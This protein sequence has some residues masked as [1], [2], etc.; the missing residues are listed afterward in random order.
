[1]KD[2][3]THEMDLMVWDENRTGGHTDLSIIWNGD[4]TAQTYADLILV[5]NAADVGNSFLLI[6]DKT[7]SHSARLLENI[8]ETKTV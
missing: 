3:S 2:N 4:L 6:S 5:L 1:M 8:I 7:R